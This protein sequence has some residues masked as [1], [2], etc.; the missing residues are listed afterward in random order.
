VLAD[1]IRQLTEVQAQITLADPT[2]SQAVYGGKSAVAT[3]LSAAEA[4]SAPREDPPAASPADP[5][6]TMPKM[7][8]VTSE[9]STMCA[10]FKSQKGFPEVAVQATVSGADL[11][12]A[13]ARR[14]QD[15]AVLADRVLVTGGSGAIVESML[16]PTAKT[17][18]MC[19]VTDEGKKY[20]IE[21]ASALQALGYGDTKPVQMP[22]SLVARIPSGPS[23]DSDA[24]KQ[25]V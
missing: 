21:D 15:G 17:G 12:P 25:P 1:K 5:P 7:A 14:T 13:T 19:L 22:A 8:D 10:S 9:K 6:D 3:P 20:A 16:S 24:A 2:L 18:A 4:N 23:L 11:A